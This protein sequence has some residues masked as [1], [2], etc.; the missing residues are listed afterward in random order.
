MLF[1]T[2]TNYLTFEE[3]YQNQPV[4]Q[5][6]ITS[7][8]YFINQKEKHVSI[9]HNSILTLMKL[10]LFDLLI[11]LINLFVL[12]FSIVSRKKKFYIKREKQ[13]SVKMYDFF[14]YFMSDEVTPVLL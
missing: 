12:F 3:I 13:Y 6:L 10:L 2:Q 5:T 8:T 4:V 9:R 1:T 11:T 14:S 7:R